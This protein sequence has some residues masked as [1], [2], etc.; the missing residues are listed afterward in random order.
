MDK[1]KGTPGIYFSSPSADFSFPL[2]CDLGA[3][4]D[5]PPQ[6]QGSCRSAIGRS[7]Q[8]FADFFANGIFVVVHE[9][10]I[11]LSA[12]VAIHATRAALPAG[13]AMSPL[14]Y[15]RECAAS[16][17]KWDGG[18]RISARSGRVVLHASFDESQSG[19]QTHFSVLFY[20]A[21]AAPQM[22]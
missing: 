14:C 10:R 11:C 22:P 2:V 3:E 20:V 6:R 4:P 21:Y 15:T 8:F 13:G 1:T 16:E 17:P 19:R 7:K 9:I 18:F 5:G 12:H